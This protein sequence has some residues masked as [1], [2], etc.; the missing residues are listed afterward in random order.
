[1]PASL[2]MYTSVIAAAGIVACS[3]RSSWARSDTTSRVPN[4]IAANTTIDPNTIHKARDRDARVAGCRCGRARAQRRAVRR[5]PRLHLEPHPLQHGEHAAVVVL[6]GRQVELGE[7]VAHVLLDAPCRSRRGRGRSPGCCGPRPSA[8]APRAR[9]ASA[10]R[11]DRAG[12]TGRAAAR[13]PRGRA[14]CR[15]RRPAARRRGTRRRRRRGPSAGSRSPPVSPAS[16]SV[17]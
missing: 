14:R 13:P 12:G 1:M 17:A 6:G 16:S 15:R 3:S 8:P 10:G 7:D 11:A 5:T 9:A 4:T 2:S